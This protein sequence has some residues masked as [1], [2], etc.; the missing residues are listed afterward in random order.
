MSKPINNQDYYLNRFFPGMERVDALTLFQS[1]FFAARSTRFMKIPVV[2]TR[3]VK[4]P[5]GKGLISMKLNHHSIQKNDYIS[6]NQQLLSNHLFLGTINPD[7]KEVSG[8]MVGNV[9]DTFQVFMRRLNPN[10]GLFT[11]NVEAET[12]A[13]DEFIIHNDLLFNGEQIADVENFREVSKDKKIL[14]AKSNWEFVIR[15][16]DDYQTENLTEQEIVSGLGNF[17]QACFKNF[18]AF[19]DFKLKGVEGLE[20]AYY[21]GDTNTFFF[22]KENG[23]N[24][25]AEFHATSFTGKE[26]SHTVVVNPYSNTLIL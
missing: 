10:E 20:Q 14:G 4:N 2:G 17:G 25:L 6:T 18:F 24:V 11:M 12:V 15:I 3:A 7:I 22:N 19:K 9:S 13:D 21:D 16:L 23:V 5:A 26:F 8:F 1:V